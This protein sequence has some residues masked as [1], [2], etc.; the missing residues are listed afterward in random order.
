[1][2]PIDS[3]A[4]RSPDE[5]FLA[6]TLK[7]EGKELS[8]YLPKPSDIMSLG[9]PSKADDFLEYLLPFPR[10]V[11]YDGQRLAEHISILGDGII[12]QF[13][14]NTG[15]LLITSWEDD[16]QDPLGPC[17]EIIISFFS[18]DFVLKDKIHLFVFEFYRWSAYQAYGESQDTNGV[19]SAGASPIHSLKTGN[20]ESLAFRL[21][22]GP[23]VWV[24]VFDPPRRGLLGWRGFLGGL[25]EPWRRAPRHLW[26]HKSFIPFFP[27]RNNE[28]PKKAV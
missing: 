5:S 28:H 9:W 22:D 23:K 10:D 3:F 26:V 16:Y 2:T 6:Y 24:K 13:R 27:R 21:K 1:M 18:N 19:L 14:T 12:A 25:C 11:Y 8:L 17:G 20:S 15:Y 4:F 7:P